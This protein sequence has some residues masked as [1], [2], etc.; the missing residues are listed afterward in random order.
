MFPLFPQMHIMPL[1]P[2]VFIQPP[3]LLQ[4]QIF[5]HPQ[6]LLHPPPFIQPPQLLHPLPLLQNQPCIHQLPPILQRPPLQHPQPPLQPPPLLQ[7]Q[8]LRPPQPLQLAAIDP[9]KTVYIVSYSSDTVDHNPGAIAQVENLIP[10]GIPTVLTIWCQTWR[11]PPG[12]ICRHYS[13][14]SPIVQSVIKRSRTAMWE[15]YVLAAKHLSS[16]VHK[17]FPLIELKTY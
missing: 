1:Q 15:M 13:G 10:L 7:P 3:P 4:P 11:A 17:Y 6:P 12:D 8:P 9:N 14:V 16:V 2:Q 5:I